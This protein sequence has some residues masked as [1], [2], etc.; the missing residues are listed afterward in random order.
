MTLR[1]VLGGVDWLLGVGW[2]DF[3]V[4]LWRGGDAF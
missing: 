1:R 3:F 4:F 2:L